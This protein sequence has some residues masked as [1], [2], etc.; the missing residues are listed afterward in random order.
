MSI[1][2]PA[3][4]EILKVEFTLPVSDSKKLENE[5]YHDIYS[6]KT[7]SVNGGDY[8]ILNAEFKPAWEPVFDMCREPKPSKMLV[9]FDLVKG[10]GNE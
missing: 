7:I 8:Y 2:I 3:N 10:E 1:K 4:A 6:P 9:S 5:L